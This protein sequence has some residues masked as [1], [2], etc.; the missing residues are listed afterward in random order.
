MTKAIDEQML[1]TGDDRTP[2]AVENAEA[3]ARCRASTACWSA[4]ATVDGARIPGDRGQI[5]TRRASTS[6]RG[7]RQARQVARPMGGAYSTSC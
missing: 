2:K 1:L 4:R 6:R 7:L 5:K 3:I